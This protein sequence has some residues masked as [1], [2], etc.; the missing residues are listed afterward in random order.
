M[1]PVI[2]DSASIVAARDVLAS[3]FDD[4]LVL[5]DLRDGVYYGLE[6][7]GARVWSLVQQPISVRAI[8]EAIVAEYDV[9]PTRCAHDLHA[10]LT[11]LAATG[12]VE[13][14]T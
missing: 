11:E 14:C 2:S 13:I 9:D 8:G 1:V 5:L 12:L 6:H 3:E 4:E 7:V 10:L